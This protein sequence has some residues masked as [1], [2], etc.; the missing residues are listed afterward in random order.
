MG[1]I[2]EQD[3]IETESQ[4][5]EAGE[6][7]AG[8]DPGQGEAQP[9]AGEVTVTIGEAPEEA[10]D[11]E[12]APGLVNKLRK[13]VRERERD[14]REVRRKLNE[15]GAVPV[16]PKLP[17]KPTLEES[18]Y[19]TEKFTVATEK[20]LEEKRKVDEHKAK[21][22]A[23]ART[24]EQ[25]W[26]EKVASYKKQ[27]S[28]TFDAEEFKDAEDRVLEAFSKEQQGIIVA[29]AKDPAYVVFGLGKNEAKAKELAAIKNLA[30]FTYALARMEAL[31][32]KVTRK[33]PATEP[34]GRIAGNS[35]PSGSVNSALERLRAE[36][37]KTGDYSKVIDYKRKLKK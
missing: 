36:A 32:V 21:M 9:E 3:Q 30:E 20:W 19:D 10:E 29:C 7:L 17:P 25:S 4:E 23:E 8:D 15:L 33:V 12:K 22:D 26:Q 13:I 6:V 2:V 24:A 27:A 18:D 14:L 11:P 1:D 31:D 37:V 5:E 34:E 16:E 28:E 35:P